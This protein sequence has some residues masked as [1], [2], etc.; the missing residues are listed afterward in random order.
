M[1]INFLKP[2]KQQTI[3]SQINSQCQEK[4]DLEKTLIIEE[5]KKKIQRMQSQPE[6]DQKNMK[7]FENIDRKLSS[8]S[9]TPPIATVTISTSNI[10]GTNCNPNVRPV[11]VTKEQEIEDIRMA[12]VRSICKSIKWEARGGKS[13]SK[14]CKTLDDRF[15]LK[16]MSKQDVTIFENFAPNYFVHFNKCL[17][18]RQP[19]LLAKIFGVFKITVKKKE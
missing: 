5:N 10:T 14:F 4:N 18:A 1:R 6:L 12:F 7:E 2:L 17:Q 9:L 15:V 19:T 11:D 13:G 16:E 8:C 3:G